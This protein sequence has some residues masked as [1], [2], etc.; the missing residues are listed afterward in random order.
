MPPGQA[1]ARLRVVDAEDFGGAA[2]SLS[3]HE[4]SFTAAAPCPG[5]AGSQPAQHSGTACSLGAAAVVEG[6]PR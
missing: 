4:Q 3:S 6:K 1:Q 5:R 2:G